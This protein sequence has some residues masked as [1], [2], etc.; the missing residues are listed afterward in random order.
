M[1][2]P[3]KTETFWR[4]LM[5]VWTVFCSHY[6]SLQIN[7]A[8]PFSLMESLEAL[9]TANSQHGMPASPELQSPPSQRMITADSFGSFDVSSTS[10]SD[11]RHLIQDLGK[12][13]IH[14]CTHME[15]LM[16]TQLLSFLLLY[17]HRDGAE[18]AHLCASL[19][20]LAREVT[21]HG[22]LLGYTGTDHDVLEYALTLLHQSIQYVEND[23]KVVIKPVTTLPGVFHLTYYANP[24]VAMFACES[25]FATALWSRIEMAAQEQP[26]KDVTVT[27]EEVI[28]ATIRLANYLHYE[29]VV[30]PP[31]QTMD[32]MLED[33]CEKLLNADILQVIHSEG[34]L[35]QSSEQEKKWA[36]RFTS[37]LQM[38]DN[39]DSGDEYDIQYSTVY[40]VKI[41]SKRNTEKLNFLKEI[42]SPLMD[43]Y[44]MTGMELNMLSSQDILEDLFVNAVHKV[45]LQHI[46]SG[47]C[48]YSESS[49]LVIIH[50]A[51]QAFERLNIVERYR[52]ESMNKAM[53]SLTPQYKDPQALAELWREL[54]TFR[55]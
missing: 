43:T 21:G 35:E 31:C 16:S 37:S 22:R 17:R 10:Q 33:V 42:I 39:E 50:N 5:G 26:Y 30:C 9:K 18:T 13:I 36:Q 55:H 6:G 11:Y 34:D 41:S 47:A 1:G 51:V 53:L 46:E 54:E 15:S 14:S 12:H 2:K 40:T 38:S 48:Q 3:K 49:S 23:D 24:V 52:D 25:L 27:K 29:F 8:Q 28:S 7:F 19:H 45:I 20:W 44:Y 32:T 4:A